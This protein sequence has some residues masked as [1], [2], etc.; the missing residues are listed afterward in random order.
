MDAHSFLL[1]LLNPV[2]KLPPGQISL[3]IIL[4]SWKPV[5]HWKGFLMDAHDFLLF[6]LN[7]VGKLP[8]GK[9]PWILLRSLEKLSV[10]EKW[11]LMD[12]QGFFFL[13]PVGRLLY[14]W[15][16]WTWIITIIC[17]SL[18]NLKNWFFSLPAINSMW[19]PPLTSK[20]DKIW[21]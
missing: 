12:A 9:D 20:W 3:N 19:G 1:F 18:C 4:E 8:Q 10:T 7:P 17:G 14:I 21:R 11:Y 6:F 2:G 15:L 13:N 5:S 16:P